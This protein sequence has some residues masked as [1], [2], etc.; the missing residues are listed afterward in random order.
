MLKL[1]VIADIVS[2]SGEPLTP[3]DLDTCQNTIDGETFRL[4]HV[5]FIMRPFQSRTAR[6]AFVTGE[7]N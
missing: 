3:L 7:P 6:G 1:V 4:C 2:W 5:P